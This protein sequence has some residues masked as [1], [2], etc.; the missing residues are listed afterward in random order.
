MALLSKVLKG[1]ATLDASGQRAGGGAAG[2]G[3][4]DAAERAKLEELAR[5]DLKRRLAA[6]TRKQL[7]VSANRTAARG[8]GGR[9]LGR[10][11]SAQLQHGA[12][13]DIS[14]AKPSAGAVRSIATARRTSWTAKRKWRGSTSQR[15]AA[16]AA[17]AHR[18]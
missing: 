4:G 7:K 17:D 18:T 2:Q 3:T 16:A 5:A 11:P 12:V 8:G 1:T 9:D 10:S 15:Y 14:L 6:A 13:S